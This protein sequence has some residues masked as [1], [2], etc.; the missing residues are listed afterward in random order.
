[1]HNK[2]AKLS[3]TNTSNCVGWSETGLLR[4]R[5]MKEPGHLALQGSPWRHLSTSGT[6]GNCDE[7]LWHST[8][9]YCEASSK[10]VLKDDKQGHVSPDTFQSEEQEHARVQ[11][12]LKEPSRAL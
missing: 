4:V 11:R 12:A 10:V 6:T 3:W 5:Q 7:G 2:H 1:M 9:D 8:E